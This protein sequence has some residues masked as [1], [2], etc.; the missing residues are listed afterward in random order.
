MRATSANSRIAIEPTAMVKKTTFVLSV[1]A[2]IPWM[3]TI[4][5]RTYD[6]RWIP[7]HS[8]RGSHFI[9]HELTWMTTSR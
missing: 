1:P 7:C 6:N 4:T 2:L 8:L 9:I 3:V 5:N